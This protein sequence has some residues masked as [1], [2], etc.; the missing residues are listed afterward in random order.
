[1]EYHVFFG[2]LITNNRTGTPVWT[3]CTPRAESIRWVAIPVGVLSMFMRPHFDVSSTS[4]DFV[5]VG[6]AMNIAT[7][8]GAIS[9]GHPW[10]LHATV[11]WSR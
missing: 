2:T 10:A 8:T 5:E 9:I 1:M 3:L 7:R 4:D 11:T 6:T